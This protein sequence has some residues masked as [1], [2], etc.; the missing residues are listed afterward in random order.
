M[1]DWQLI[2]KKLDGRNTLEDERDLFKW[3]RK[4]PNNKIIL[5][6][7]LARWESKSNKIFNSD[8]AYQKIKPQIRG[9]KHRKSAWYKWSAVAASI[10]LMIGA[11]Y[12]FNQK[13]SIAIEYITQ[14]ADRGEKGILTLPDGSVVYLNGESSITYQK[15]FEQRNI[16]LTG[17][18]FFEVT[19]NPDKPFVVKSQG[20]Q[21]TVLG[22][23]FDINAY[24]E[25][26]TVSVTVATGKVRV[27]TEQKTSTTTK[28]NFTQVGH[29]G[30]ILTP[31]DQAVWSKNSQE[32]N[33]KS[34]SLNNHLAW[35]N[36]TI[37]LNNVTLESAAKTLGRWYGV[38]INV[39]GKNAK[40]QIIYGQF[41]NDKLGYI[42]EN[43][44][45]LAH[46]EYEKIAPKEYLI[47]KNSSK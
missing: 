1:I 10:L 39:E 8:L 36:G 11:S 35:K 41:K 5:D 47:T 26:K 38:T 21:T 2:Q 28:N 42:L 24:P 12:F 32:I 25:N 22:T 17:Q 27:E 43:I 29:N 13:E 14:S 44:K 9:V 6:D 16:A 46:I 45:F 18:A 40:Q 4:S 34:V 37:I 30:V 15:G 23:S 20:L 33:T 19:K 7:L 31:N 3:V